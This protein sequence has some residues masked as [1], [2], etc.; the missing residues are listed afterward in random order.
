MSPS[1]PSPRPAPTYSIPTTSIAS[2]EYPG[3]VRNT[4]T[5][6]SAALTTL[7]GPSKVSHSLSSLD[8][9]LQLNFRPHAPFSH[10][11]ASDT[12][13]EGEASHA[14]V[15]KVVK[16][17][18]RRTKTKIVGEQVLDERGVYTVQC[19][20]RVERVVRFRAM[21]DLQY[22]QEWTRNDPTVQLAQA[23]KTMNGMATLLLQDSTAKADA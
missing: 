19:L 11:L 12:V 21:A 3:P 22:E 9:I 17:S 5:S 15:L 18:R 4:P 6:L 1:E 10:S 8:S 16:R 2:I 14:V 7:G 13:P 20:G 23:L